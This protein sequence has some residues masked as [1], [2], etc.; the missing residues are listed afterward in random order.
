MRLICNHVAVYSTV[1]LNQKATVYIIFSC[2]FDLFKELQSTS[3][4]V[5]HQT[6]IMVVSAKKGVVWHTGK[7]LA[8]SAVGPRFKPQQGQGIL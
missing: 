7:V 2:F 1:I 8:C 3:F 4:T 5:F 6:G